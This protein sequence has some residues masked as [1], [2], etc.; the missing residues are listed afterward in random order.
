MDLFLIFGGDLPSIALI[1]LHSLEGYVLWFS[2]SANCLHVFSPM[3]VCCSGD[4]VA[5][6]L[7]GG[8]GGISRSEVIS[9]SHPFQYF[10]WDQL[11]INTGSARGCMV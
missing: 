5:H 9:Y 8:P 3:F 1:D 11:C 2:V 4:L 10:R 7:Q 6:L